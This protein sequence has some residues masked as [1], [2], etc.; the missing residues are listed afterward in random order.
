MARKG[1]TVQLQAEIT[2][3]DEFAKFL[4]KDELLSIKLK[5]LLIAI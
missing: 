1:A 4:Q 3:D 2:T 5:F